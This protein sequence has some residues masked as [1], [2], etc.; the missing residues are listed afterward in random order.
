MKYYNPLI[1][2]FYAILLIVAIAS[3]WLFV[4]L[5][6]EQPPQANNI[7]VNKNAKIIRLFS[8]SAD[9][10]NNYVVQKAVV[11]LSDGERIVVLANNSIACEGE[12]YT[13]K[14][15]KSSIALGTK[16]E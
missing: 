2:S 6:I 13:L 14:K 1:E 11:E 9:E 8:E 5:S 4:W 15:H 16:L 3:L 10:Y 12:I 7:Y